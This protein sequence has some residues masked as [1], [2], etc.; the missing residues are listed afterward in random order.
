MGLAVRIETAHRRHAAEPPRA[1]ARRPAGHAADHAGIA[2]RCC[3]PTPRRRRCF[4]GLGARRGR[5]AAR[6]GRHQARRPA[7]A[8][9]RAAGARWRRR[10]GGSASRRRWRIREPLRAWLSPSGEPADVRAGARAPAAPSPTS[11]I[12]LPEGRLPWA[13]PLWAGLRAPRHLR[14]DPATRRHHRVRQHPRPGRADVPGAVAA[15]RRRPADRAAPRQPRRRAAPQGRGGDGGGQAARGGLHLLARPRHRLGRGRPRRPGRRAQGRRRACCSGSAAPTTASTSRAARCWCRPTA[16]RCWSAR[17]A[18]RCDRARTRWT[19][20]RRARAG[21][22]C[23]PAPARHRL[24]RALPT[25]TRSIAEVARAAPYA[26]LARRDFDDVLRFV[27][28]GGYALA[29]LRALPPAVRGRGRPVARAP[30]GAS[31]GATA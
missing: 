22:T 11:T 5:R 8:R 30:T 1:P 29:R 12:L 23:W 16:S 6:A 9:P 10:R 7:G 17:A 25:P 19:A 26:A 21:S 27:A 31:R 4:A 24:Q 3:C 14:A 20:T 13:R 28:T 18:H 15:Q 2:W